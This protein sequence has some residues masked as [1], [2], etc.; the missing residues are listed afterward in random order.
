MSDKDINVLS[1]LEE[2]K[3][4]MKEIGFWNENPPKINVSNYTE[5]PSF[6]LWL[7]CVFIPSAIKSAT[8][9][10]YPEGSQ[11]G[12]MA[13]REY[14]YHSNIEEAQNLL[15]LLQSFDKLVTSE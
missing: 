9:G 2:I 3:R 14:D 13:M 12:L 5:A 8:S 7:Q 6:E 15:S 11:V 1:V 10:K 4:E